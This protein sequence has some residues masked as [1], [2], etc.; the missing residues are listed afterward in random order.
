M[1]SVGARGAFCT[2]IILSNNHQFSGRGALRV[3]N[4][5]DF[6]AADYGYDSLRACVIGAAGTGGDIRVQGQL[7]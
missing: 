7:P 2:S 4:R 1:V 5:R 3:E 6:H